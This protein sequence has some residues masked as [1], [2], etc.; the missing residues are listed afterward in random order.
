M[1][2]DRGMIKWLPFK[3]LPEQEEF[4][5]RHREERNRVE[6]PVLSSDQLEAM[7][8]VLSSLSPG[9]RIDLTV[10]SDGR[11]ESIG[12]VF[13][14]IRNGCIATDDGSFSPSEIIG[15]EAA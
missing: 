10:F 8:D 11:I 13:R 12:T 9:D 3:S 6:C 2:K 1:I 5:S 7:D 14:G 4:L 15:I